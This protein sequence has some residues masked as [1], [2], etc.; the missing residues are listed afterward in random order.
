MTAVVLLAH[1]PL[2]R[3]EGD[4]VPFTGGSLWSMPFDVFDDLTAGAFTDHR[5]RYEE[6]APVFFRLDTPLDLPSTDGKERKGQGELKVPTDNWEMLN[7][8]D[9]GFMALS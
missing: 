8:L 5:A 9:L 3:I 1:V 7:S 6:T 4:E 2:L